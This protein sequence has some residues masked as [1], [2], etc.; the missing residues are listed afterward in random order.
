MHT[1]RPQHPLRRLNSPERGIQ[2]NVPQL[3]LAIA[4]PAHEFAQAPALHVHVGDPL[5]VVAPGLDHGG[6]GLEALV[7]DA[8]DA[9]AEAGDED[10]AGDLVRGQGGDAG[11]GACGDVLGRLVRGEEMGEWVGGKGTFVQTSVAAFQTRM[12]LTSP[13]TSNLPCP[14]CQSKT[15]PAFL[16]LGTRSVKARKAETKSTCFSDS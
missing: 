2:P 15:R 5:L 11:A 3:D 12:T 10:V 9:V 1:Q 6:A 8:D 13:A 4:T 14:C 16:L 7:E